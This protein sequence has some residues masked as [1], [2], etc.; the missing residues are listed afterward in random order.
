[1]VAA[2]VSRQITNYPATLPIGLYASKGEVSDKGYPKDLSYFSLDAASESYSDA[3]AAAKELWGNEPVRLSGLRFM[4]QD[5][6][7]VLAASRNEQWAKGGGG[8]QLMVA[9]EGYAG[10]PII[11]EWDGVNKKFNRASRIC[12]AKEDGC[13]DTCKPKVKLYV[14]SRT[15]FERVGKMFLISLSL[16]GLYDQ[17][18]L[19]EVV[20]L[21]QQ[22]SF[23]Q[24][25]FNEIPF[26]LERYEQPTSFEKEGK[27]ISRTNYPVRLRA[28]SVSIPSLSLPPTSNHTTEL[29]DGE[30]Q[31]VRGDFED[32]HP[33]EALYSVIMASDG[34]RYVK[35][36]EGVDSTVFTNESKDGLHKIVYAING[37]SG[38]DMTK[39]VVD[40]FK[41]SIIQKGCS[42][43][44]VLDVILSQTLDPIPF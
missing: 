7:Q 32:E 37:M 16:G 12:S 28:D 24:M 26:T 5:Y 33:I 20:L 3:L 34:S 38:A 29:G 13:C 2:F 14:Y 1:M 25:P 43:Q 23:L 10:K 42:Y 41:A 39:A 40:A 44:Q 22:A 15:L 35:L 19:S 11:K 9:C 4:A 18:V 8:S 21:S 6:N 31:G 36:S 17:T 30:Q 27:K